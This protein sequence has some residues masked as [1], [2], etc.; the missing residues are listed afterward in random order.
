MKE[1]LLVALVLLMSS[2]TTLHAQ[3]HIAPES[4]PRIT[5]EELKQ[6]MD[7]SNLSIIDVRAAGDWEDSTTRIK[8]SIREDPSKVDSWMAK[9]PSNKTIV[10]Y[11][12]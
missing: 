12:A 2:V 3:G 10:F 7:N 11:C 8:G 4:V 6:Q 1:I 5:I 9:Y